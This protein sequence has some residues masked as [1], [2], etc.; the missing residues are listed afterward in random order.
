[1]KRMPLLLIAGLCGCARPAD[2]QPR[3]ETQPANDAAAI[4][5]PAPAQPAA[6]APP[7]TP[8]GLPDDRTP[9]AE[10]QGKIDPKSAEAAGQAL[11]QFGALV[12]QRRYQEAARLWSNSGGR[13]QFDAAF[14][15]ATEVHLQVGKPGQMEGA[16]GSSYVEVPVVVYGKDGGKSFSRSGTAVLR[17]V[18]DVPG[19]TAE[20]RRWHIERIELKSAA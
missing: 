5:D 11:Q 20:Q 19:S 8:G 9:L 3:N 1:M 6:P 4:G 12:E 2:Q 17:R 7:G 18:N 14:N 13:A 15:S 10:P 16:A